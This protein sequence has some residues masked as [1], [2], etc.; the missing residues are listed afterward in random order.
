MVEGGA[1]TAT[2]GP[3]SARGRVRVGCACGG[4][5]ASAKF[6]L[7]EHF[8]HNGKSGQL[9]DP[10]SATLSFRRRAM[11]PT[12]GLGFEGRIFIGGNFGKLPTPGVQTRRS[13]G[14]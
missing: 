14:E 2:G 10:T 4:E 3:K 13:R 9:F 11:G 7:T 12:H 8:S 5:A 6:E 1:A